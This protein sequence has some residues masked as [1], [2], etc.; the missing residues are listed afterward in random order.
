MMMF[1]YGV[2]TVP[3]GLVA[4]AYRLLARRR[5]S[6]QIADTILLWFASAYGMFMTHE[7]VMFVNTS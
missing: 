2:V 6:R 7:C 4:F 5:S 3:L 1:P